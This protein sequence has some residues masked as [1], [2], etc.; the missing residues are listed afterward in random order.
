MYEHQREILAERSN[1]STEGNIM[2]E[3]RRKASIIP[4]RR[5]THIRFYKENSCAY[6]PVVTSTSYKTCRSVTVTG[7][8]VP[9]YQ[10]NV[11]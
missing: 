2:R 5:Q 11:Q 1:F 7:C 8:R 9:G 6:T 3:N 10:G 4:P